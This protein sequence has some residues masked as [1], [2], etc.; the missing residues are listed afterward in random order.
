MSGFDGI[1][2][3]RRRRRCSRPC[4]ARARRSC[5]RRSSGRCRARCSGRTDGR[6]PPRTARFGVLRI[7]DDLRDL[8]RVAQAEVR[9]RLAGVGGL[10]DA[11]AGRQVGP[12]L[13]LAGADVDDVGIRGR[14]RQRADRAG[15]LLVED[16][17]PGAAGVGGLPHAAVDDADVEG[18]R[19]ARHAVERLG[20]AGAVRADVAPLHFAK[21]SRIEAGRPLGLTRPRPRRQRCQSDRRASARAGFAHGGE[22]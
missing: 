4:R 15:G 8:L 14:H 7:D 13:R 9:P 6:A 12:L 18:V 16:R 20:A 19:L 2:Q 22:V 1:E 11:V 10:V 21:Q 3:R 17:Q 5:R